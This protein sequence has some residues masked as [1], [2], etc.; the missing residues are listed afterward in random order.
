M[1]RVAIARTM[2][3]AAA[4]R[5]GRLRGFAAWWGGAWCSSECHVAQL[6]DAD[7]YYH[8][9][10]WGDPVEVSGT[11]V[12]LGPADGEI[13]IWAMPFDEFKTLSAI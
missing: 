13:Y 8:S 5:I 9:A 3:V 1:E 4:L 2:R 6:A 12:Q 10:I 7:A 11:S